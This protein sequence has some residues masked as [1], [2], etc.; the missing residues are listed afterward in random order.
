[1]DEHSRQWPE[2]TAKQMRA[3]FNI[4]LEHF[5]PDRLLGEI[6][7][8]DASEVKKVLQAL[9]VNRNTK[10]ALKD[11]PL[12]E[13][14]KVKGQKTIAPKTINGHIDTF[15]RFFDWAERHGHAPHK[16]FEGMKVPKAKNA[17]TDRKPFS[18]E[19]TRLIYSELTEN[20]S[21]LTRKESHKWGSLLG[22]Y[23]GARLN[24]ICQLD[25]ADVQ[26][27]GDIWF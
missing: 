25:V 24:E 2:K 27:E 11:L 3:Y 1:M 18:I 4:L 8:Q 12:S 17:E 15:R 21:G 7:K 14:I 9:P 10:P 20:Q 5:G 23:T 16:L 26:R 6:S 22:L 19:Q 13:V